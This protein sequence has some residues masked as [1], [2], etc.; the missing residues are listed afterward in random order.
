Q[1]VNAVNDAHYNDLLRMDEIKQE[2]DEL[3]E[4]LY[5]EQA[6][7]TALHAALGAQ[8]GAKMGSPDAANEDRD[9]LR[10]VVVGNPTPAQC[11]RALGLIFGDRVIVLPSAHASAAEASDFRHGRELWDLLTRL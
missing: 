1:N 3:A 2:K 4:S 5:K 11:L 9:A 6:K 8:R 10:S 7:S